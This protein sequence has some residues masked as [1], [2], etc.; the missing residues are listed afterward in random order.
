MRGRSGEIADEFER[1]KGVVLADPD[2][3]FVF[4]LRHYTVHRALPLIGHR[5]TERAGEG[6]ESEVQLDVVTLRDWDRWSNVSQHFLAQSVDLIPLRPLIRKHGE[7]V[8]EL[9]V[10]LHNALTALN[11]PRLSEVNQLV[12]ARNTILV[13]GDPELGKRITAETTARRSSVPEAPA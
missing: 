3:R 2:V 7:L 9:N 12:L 4:E 10:W 1:R 13:G 6:L 8:G 11:A 5:F